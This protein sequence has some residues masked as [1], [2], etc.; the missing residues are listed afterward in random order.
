MSHRVLDLQPF[1]A[2]FKLANFIIILISVQS[3]TININLF[4]EPYQHSVCE[5]VDRE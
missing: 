5:V 1:L 3:A 4:L 2:E